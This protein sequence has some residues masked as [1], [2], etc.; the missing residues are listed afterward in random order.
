LFALLAALAGCATQ[1]V[2]ISNLPA[3]TPA[4]D[5]AAAAESRTELAAAV[6][7]EGTETAENGEPPPPRFTPAD[8]PSMRTY[9]PWE[10]LNRFTY[11]FNARFDSAVFLP[12]ANGYQRLPSPLRTGVHNFFDN[13]TELSTMIN[14]ALQWRLGRGVHSLGRFLV[15]STIGI[16]GLIDVAKHIRLPSAPTGFSNTLGTWGI[17]PGPYLVLP[18]FGPSTL[19]DTIGLAGD[20]GTRYGINLFDLYRGPL[21]KT[22]SM[23]V[24]D[25]V[26]E[27]ANTA[28]RYYATGS[29]FEY[30]DIRFLYVRKRLL[31]DTGLHRHERP[32]RPVPGTPAGQ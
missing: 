7:S 30:D 15:N 4:A 6:A 29:P 25:A 18:L 10:R 21:W 23:D 31:E 17:H 1:G 3:A 2:D 22:G 27:R 32:K 20:I 9:D 24:V 13:L 26:D 5:N 19:R 12:V 16:G 14:Y 28:F 8:A 11:R